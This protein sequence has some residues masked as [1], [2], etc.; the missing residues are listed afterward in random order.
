MNMCMN[1]PIALHNAENTRGSQ[2][3]KCKNDCRKHV[4]WVL[5]KNISG[6]LS[7]TRPVDSFLGWPRLGEDKLVD[8]NSGLSDVS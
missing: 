7:P 4:P 2:M 1:K 6:K 5:A 3:A 8:L